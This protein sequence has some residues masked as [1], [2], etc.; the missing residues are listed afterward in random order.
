M[1]DAAWRYGQCVAVANG[2]GVMPQR[3]M[4]RG[5]GARDGDAVAGEAAG[6]GGGGGGDVA[7]RA[8]PPLI[9]SLIRATS[10]PV[11]AAGG[12]AD[13]PVVEWTQA[14]VAHVALVFAAWGLTRVALPEPVP[15]PVLE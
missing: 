4:I 9:M 6:G 3:G 12:A 5:V 1:L 7:R 13:A 2:A 14:R 8:E 15:V 11:D 10:E